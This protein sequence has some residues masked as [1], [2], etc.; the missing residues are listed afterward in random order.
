MKG[1]RPTLELMARVY[2]LSTSG[3]AESERFRKYI[4]L[5][6]ER[7][8]INLY[9]PMTS[10]PEAS[11]TIGALLR[12]GAENLAADALESL[13]VDPSEWFLT[14]A[15]PGAW[16]DRLFTEIEWRL[17]ADTHLWFWAGE[18][19]NIDMVV[20][21]AARAVRRRSWGGGAASL[22]EYAGQEGVAR[23]VLTECPRNLES[24]RLAI[25]LYGE[26][27]SDD[28]MIALTFGDSIAED[29]GWKGLG[30][31]DETGLDAAAWLFGL[32]PEPGA[33]WIP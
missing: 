25:D 17:A 3:G 27:T 16:T 31:G 8:P 29:G 11:E 2:G 26:D 33:R 9:N 10:R 4:Q 12:I 7:H 23:G 30:I 22:R 21:S 14:V 28:S 20:E 1:L 19:P 15:T 32:E 18:E 6:E 24:V 13:H 5:C